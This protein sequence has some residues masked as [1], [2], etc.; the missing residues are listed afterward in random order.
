MASNG[1][2]NTSGYD[3]RYLNFSWSEKSQ[4]VTNNTT[5]I[6]WTLK[7]AGGSSMWYMSGNFKVVI[8]GVTVYS[9]AARIQLSNGSTVASGTYTFQHNA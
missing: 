2:F 8:D 3:G 9:S 4:S 6:S 7:G 1:S 5:T